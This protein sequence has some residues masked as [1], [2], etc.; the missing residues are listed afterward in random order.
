M[1]YNYCVFIFFIE[2][3]FRKQA[4]YASRQGENMKYCFIINPASGKKTTKDGLEERIREVCVKRGVEADIYFTA[5]RGDARE[6]VRNYVIDA[7]NEVR[8]YACG[9]DG[10]LCECISGL[11]ERNTRDNV[12]VGVIPVGTGNDFVRCFG[13]AQGFLDISA[14]LDATPMEIDVIKCND[15]YAVNMINVGFDCQVVVKTAEMKKKS[16]IPSKFAYIAGLILTL[17]KKPGAVFRSASDKNEN[18]TLKL[19]LAT[20]A[21]GKYCGGG[22][23][24]N[25]NSRLDDG[26]INALFVDDISRIRFLSI[27]GRYKSGTHLDGKNDDIFSENDSSDFELEFDGPTNISI[28]GEIVTADRIKLTCLNRVARFLVPKGICYAN[29]I[30]A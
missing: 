4:V 16:F 17:I 19:L 24:S 9:G 7:S 22:F 29:G 15:D 8:F 13:G 3:V 26:V 14:Q 23:Y 30:E 21:N 10:T 1:W 20:F 12:S 18:R 27:V 2:F 6:Y 25:P 11:M 5:C 28:D